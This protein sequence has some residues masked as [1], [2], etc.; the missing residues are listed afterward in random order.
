MGQDMSRLLHRLSS[1]NALAIVLI[2]LFGSGNCASASPEGEPTP[3]RL[4]SRLNRKLQRYTGITAATDFVA[5]EATTLGLWLKF[6]GKVRA[7]VRTYSFTDLLSGKIKS[8]DITMK[9][10]RY[11]GVP[12]DNLHI[13]T[14]TPI[15][16]RY[17]KRDRQGAGVRSPLLVKIAGSVSGANVAD[18]LASPVVSSSLKSIKLELPGLGGQRLQFLDPKVAI[19]SDTI[20]IKSVLV[21]AG[22]TAETGVPIKLTGKPEL[23]G[24]SKII[25]SNLGVDSV[26]IPNP[27]EF[28]D[29]TSKLLN[30]LIDFARKDRV[31]HAFRLDSLKVLDDQVQFNGNLLLA[32][33]VVNPVVA[34][35]VI[36]KRCH[37]SK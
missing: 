25:I 34:Q 21:T 5:S 20:E 13:A 1:K 18:G 36:K 37:G 19:H 8:L 17:F 23:V 32:P 24:N 27:E 35:Q 10:S 12:L 15:W 2:I 11:E 14:A 7:K 6:H 3:F 16:L 28:A 22:A 9:E 26:D 29:F 33:R 4:G 30:P 31:T